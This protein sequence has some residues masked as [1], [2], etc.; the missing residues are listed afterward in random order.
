MDNIVDKV[1]RKIIEFLFGRRIKGEP[2]NLK[3]PTPHKP[4]PSLDK[5]FF[6]WCEEYRV[7]CLAKSTFVSL[8]K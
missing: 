2:V 5:Q 7:G 3:Y 6:M 1:K 4:L 8:I